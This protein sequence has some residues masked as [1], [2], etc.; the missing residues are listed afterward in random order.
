[1]IRRRLPLDE[2]DVALIFEDVHGGRSVLPPHLVPTRPAL[3]R[4]DPARGPAP[5]N[6]VL[7]EAADADTHARAC[8]GVRALGAPRE[9]VLAR[10]DVLSPDEPAPRQTPAQLWGAEAQAVYE[11]HAREIERCRMADVP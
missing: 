6:V 10:E 7:M 2:E 8:F 9:F 11:R 4:W 1:M 3:T 5:D